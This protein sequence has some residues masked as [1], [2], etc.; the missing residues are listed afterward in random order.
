MPVP[1]TW[2]SANIRVLG[3]NNNV[4]DISVTGD[5]SIWYLKCRVFS[6]DE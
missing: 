2:A 1:A 5:T 6:D 4:T 3:T